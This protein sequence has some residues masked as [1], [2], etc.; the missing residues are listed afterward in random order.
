[1]ASDAPDYQRV[2]VLETSAMSDAPDWQEVIVGPG[3]SPIGGGGG[4]FWDLPGDRG[5][6]AW[7][8]P[9]GLALAYRSYSQEL[10]GGLTKCIASTQVDNV[11]CWPQYG[12]SGLMYGN[13]YVGIYS[14]TVLA[15][16]VTGLALV[17]SSAPGVADAYF[18]QTTVQAVPLSVPYVPTVGDFYYTVVLA[19]DNGNGTANF[20]FSEGIN[21]SLVG[22]LPFAVALMP[23]AILLTGPYS[24]LP[25]TLTAESI[26]ETLAQPI[27]LAWS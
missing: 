19:D 5:W 4:G 15:G 14:L 10:W 2:V 1:M 27:W 16:Q 20:H 8:F 21:A 9:F 6:L 7:D 24:D 3:G 26:G 18:A 25:A 11:V 23:Y 17:A 13:N 12:G 22:T